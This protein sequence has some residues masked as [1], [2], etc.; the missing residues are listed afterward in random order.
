MG[1]HGVFILEFSHTLLTIQRST[2]MFECLI[3]SFHFLTISLRTLLASIR[4]MGGC[5]CPRCLIP[6]HRVHNLGMPKDKKDR[7][8]HA[9]VDNVFRKVLIDSSRRSIYVNNRPVNSKLVESDLK[10]HSYVPI[11]VSSLILWHDRDNSSINHLFRMP[12]QSVS[13]LSLD[14]IC[15]TCLW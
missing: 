10:E 11:R 1:F 3:L 12:F 5:P 15:L 13:A 14:L 6:L 8:I 9:R 4:N 2:L 7:K